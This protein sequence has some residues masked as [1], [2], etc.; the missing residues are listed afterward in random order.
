MAEPLAKLDPREIGALVALL[1]RDRLP[2][3]EQRTRALLAAHPGAG[4]LW[5]LLS[6]TLVRQGKDAM[7]ALRRAAELLPQDAEA[8]SNLGSALHDRGQ[9]TEALASLRQ[10]LAIQ[11]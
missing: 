6:V 11:P 8:H 3:A 2:E 9:W 7:P 5:K 4:V 10:A 1:E